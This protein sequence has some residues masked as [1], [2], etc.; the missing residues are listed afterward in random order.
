MNFFAVSRNTL[1]LMTLFA[2]GTLSV[3]TLW[4]ETIE[5]EQISVSDQDELRE[6]LSVPVGTDDKDVPI[7]RNNADVTLTGNIDVTTTRTADIKDSDGNVTGTATYADNTIEVLADNVK[8]RGE[9]HEI[10]SSEID[11]DVNGSGDLFF[12]DGVKLSVENITFAGTTD[13]TKKTG[14]VFL[15]GNAVHSILDIGAG[16]VFENRRLV[17]D[18]Y[19]NYRARGG[20]LVSA[21]ILD[22]VTLESSASE[23][24]SG[25]IVFRG[26]LAHGKVLSSTNSDGETVTETLD[27]A[28]GAV[29][30]S[31]LLSVSGAGTTLF[32]NNSAISDAGTAFGGA[33]FVVNASLNK[34]GSLSDSSIYPDSVT[35]LTGKKKFGLQVTETTLTFS[36]N[37]AEGA[38]AQG[39]AIAVSGGYFD[40]A[41]AEVSFTGNVAKNT[42]VGGKV[43]GGAIQLGGG[44]KVTFDAGTTTFETNLAEAGAAQTTVGGGALA[45]SGATLSLA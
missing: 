43:F 26:N 23:D 28:G 37:S 29:F 2:A 14:R 6:A 15:L 10:S 32:E 16:T 45:V 1:S 35:D 36:G 8:L 42:A 21:R 40:A 31:G 33:I 7:Y 11:L 34:D 39:G 5:R 13:A 24:G 3:S 22:E 38:N 9:G 27:A 20:A 30:A 19:T 25:D 12:L 4:A 18:E 17:A 44:A 41:K